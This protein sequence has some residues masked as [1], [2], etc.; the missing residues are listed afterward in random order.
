MLTKKQKVWLIRKNDDFYFYYEKEGLIKQLEFSKDNK[1]LKDKFPEN[2]AKIIISDDSNNKSDLQKFLYKIDSGKYLITTT[3]L[4]NQRKQEVCTL[5][6]SHLKLCEENQLQKFLLNN[7]VDAPKKGAT[8]LD[9]KKNG[10]VTKHVNFLTD[11]KE[12]KLLNEIVLPPKKKFD[13]YDKLKMI[14]SLL[15][16]QRDYLFELNQTREDLK[17]VPVRVVSDIHSKIHTG[18]DICDPTLE[19]M[20]TNLSAYFS[21]VFQKRMYCVSYKEDFTKLVANFK[22]DESKVKAKSF[23]VEDTRGLTM[24]KK[25]NIDAS[26]F[27]YR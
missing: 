4:T 11:F 1:N 7:F 13:E 10:Q 23:S 25:L 24:A 21:A 17:Q 16:W 15:N 27:E 26:E 6:N 2:T 19:A 12:T 20:K 9:I 18:M 3:K 8:L 22:V 14:D 5:T